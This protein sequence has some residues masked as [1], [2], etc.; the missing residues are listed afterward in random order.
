[1]TE[2]LIWN[3]VM[4]KQWNCYQNIK[5]NLSFIQDRVTGWVCGTYSGWV[6]AVG[7]SIE[8]VRIPLLVVDVRHLVTAVIWYHMNTH[9]RQNRQSSISINYR[10]QYSLSSS[11]WRSGRI[12][13]LHMGLNLYR[14][15]NIRGVFLFKRGCSMTTET[16]DTWATQNIV[17]LESSAQKERSLACLSLSLRGCRQWSEWNT[18][19]QVY[20]NVC[21]AANL[22]PCIWSTNHY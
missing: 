3:C 15:G 5:N 2:T 6:L 10:Q 4:T 19:T 18:R 20:L 9:A 13:L 14:E 12:W 11:D 16:N 1:M 21:E 22:D 17:Y 8:T 7:L